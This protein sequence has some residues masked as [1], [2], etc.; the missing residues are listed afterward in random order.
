MLNIAPIRKIISHDEQISSVMSSL[1]LNEPI[2]ITLSG[3]TGVLI[4]EAAYEGL[5]ETIRILQE[6]P[7]IV[8]SLEERE[9]GI[10][11]DEGDIEDYV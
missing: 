11:I 1:L 9:S 5:L 8:K 6:N 3:K 2:K 4:D 10:F 7:A